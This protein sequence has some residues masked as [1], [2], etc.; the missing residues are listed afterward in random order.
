MNVAGRDTVGEAT[1]DGAL[2]EDAIAGGGMTGATFTGTGT[3]MA[4]STEAAIA[5][6]RRS[7]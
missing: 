7:R 4:A 1:N 2:P 5:L 3:I 6:L